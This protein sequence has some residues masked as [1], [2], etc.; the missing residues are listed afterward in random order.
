[1]RCSVVLLLVAGLFSVIPPQAT[2]VCPS[3]MSPEVFCEDFD[4]YCA[5]DPCHQNPPGKCALGAT[6]DN[7]A[8]MAVWPLSSINDANLHTCGNEWNI[9]DS[10]YA[11]SLPFGLRHPCQ[12]G[13]ALGQVA[14]DLSGGIRAAYGSQ[15]EAMTGTDLH[16]LILTANLNGLTG[17]KIYAANSFIELAYAS[18]HASTDYVNS[19]DCAT[20]CGVTQAVLP[21]VCAQNASVPGCPDVAAA[22]IHASIAVGYVAFL[23]PNPCHCGESQH[24]SKN[25]K[26]AFFDGKQWWNLRA[27]LF[28]GSGDFALY[29]ERATVKLTIRTSTV[30]IEYTST[31]PQPNKYSIATIPRAYL[32]SFDRLRTGYTAGCELNSSSWEC[33]VAPRRCVKAGPGGGAVVYDDIVLYGG[34]GD[35][36]RGACCLAEDDCLDLIE[37]DCQALGGTWKGS[38]STCASRI[39]SPNPF[40]DKDRDGDV[41]MN[42]FAAFQRCVTTGAGSPAVRV[43]CGSFDWNSDGAIDQA[44]LDKFVLCASAPGMP[45]DMACDD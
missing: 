26:L 9:E 8:M 25:A 20:A 6:K 15:Y 23:D 39:C 10:S 43:G 11:F 30:Q 34:A 16:P 27:G 44:D 32:G 45:A 36:P 4:C 31:T 2:A 12:S 22:P 24:G 19:P 17:G 35:G 38:A 1:M 33:A 28:P 21:I 14:P 29:N 37:V 41:D 18:D 40:A 5:G 3:G 13:F 42:D 7:V